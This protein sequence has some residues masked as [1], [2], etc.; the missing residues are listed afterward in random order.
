M[1]GPDKVE[2]LGHLRHWD[3]NREDLLDHWDKQVGDVQM[4]IFFRQSV[5]NVEKVGKTCTVSVVDSESNETKSYTTARVIL[6]IE[7]MSNPRKLGCPGEDLEKVRN[8]L[9]DP[10]EFQG[11]NVLVV[12]GT[13]SA[14][15]VALALKDSNKVWFSCRSAKFDRVKPTNLELFTKAIES[16]EIT[17][18]WSTEVK[19]SDEESAIVEHRTNNEQTTVP[20]DVI[21]AMIGGHPPMKFLESIGVPYIERP[22]SWSPP[23][24]DELVKDSRN[25]Q[26]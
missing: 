17:A 20:N 13:D 10:D 19:G 16:G 1:A 3:T 2:M 24:S 23:A 11:K 26:V 18:L 8:S 14:I 6:A 25:L 5:T 12:G 4:P 7:T 9:V 21:I 15:E 22:H